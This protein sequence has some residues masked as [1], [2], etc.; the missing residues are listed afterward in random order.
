MF[1]YE[2]KKTSVFEL[3]HYEAPPVAV[4]KART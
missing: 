3:I 2:E 1:L 4:S